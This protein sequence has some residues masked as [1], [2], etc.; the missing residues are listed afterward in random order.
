MPLVTKS[1]SNLIKTWETFDEEIRNL[2]KIFLE[3]LT[4]YFRIRPNDFLLSPICSLALLEPK[5]L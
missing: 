2:I 5:Y 4:K 3:K 1:F